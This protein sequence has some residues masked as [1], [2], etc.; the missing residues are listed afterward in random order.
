LK[1]KSITHKYLGKF[2]SYQFLTEHAMNVNASY[3]HFIICRRSTGECFT[4]NVKDGVFPEDYFVLRKKVKYGI[5]EKASKEEIEK[6]RKEWENVRNKFLTQP[7]W[8]LFEGIEKPESKSNVAGAI[9]L[10]I[11]CGVVWAI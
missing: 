5:P 11:G 4:A 1:I 9:A 8:E 10:L 3:Y 2:D 7:D 6:F